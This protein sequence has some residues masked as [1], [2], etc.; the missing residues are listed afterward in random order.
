MGDLMDDNGNNYNIPLL[1]ETMSDFA[2]PRKC[3][4]CQ[5]PASYKTSRADAAGDFDP[6]SRQF[7]CFDH[8]ETVTAD[9]KTSRERR[10]ERL[11]ERLVHNEV[12]QR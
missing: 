3:S 8:R 4:V 12:K 10:L 5:S 2:T 11:L 1:V 7:R 9:W 6:T